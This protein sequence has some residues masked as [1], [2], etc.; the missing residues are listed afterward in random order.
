M[1]IGFGLLLSL[2]FTLKFMDDAGPYERYFSLVFGSPFLM[3]GLVLCHSAIFNKHA[4]KRFRE[5]QDHLIIDILM[6]GFSFSRRRIAKSEILRLEEVAF[7]S[8]KA[9]ILLRTPRW[10]FHIGKS[11]NADHRQW[12]LRFLRHVTANPR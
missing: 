5:D 8:R 9:E 2:I 12:L 7:G 6:F 4:Q 3:L 10:I 11:L 1:A